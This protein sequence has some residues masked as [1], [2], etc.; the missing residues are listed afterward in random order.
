[1]LELA[2]EYRVCPNLKIAIIFALTTLKN[3]KGKPLLATRKWQNQLSFSILINQKARHNGLQQLRGQQLQEEHCSREPCP[4]PSPPPPAVSQLHPGKR[5]TDSQ[6]LLSH[7]NRVRVWR[8][9][10]NQNVNW[11]SKL[12]SIAQLTLHLFKEGERSTS[13]IRKLKKKK[14]LKRPESNFY[15]LQ[16]EYIK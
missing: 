6:L 12:N 1:M 4:R 10:G 3:V 16:L 9:Q 5:G 2:K 8:D 13:S 15:D 11:L 7:E 14:V